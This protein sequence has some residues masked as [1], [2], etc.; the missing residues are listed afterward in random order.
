[1]KI[2][3]KVILPVLFVAA[4][5]IVSV[6]WLDAGYGAEKTV[7]PSEPSELLSKGECEISIYD[8]VFRRVGKASGIDWRL[9]SAMAYHESRFH[10]GA[11]SSRGAVGLMQIMPHVARKYGVSRKDLLNPICNIEL[12]A[13][14]IKGVERSMQLPRTIPADD[15]LALMLACYNGGYAHISD[16][17]NLAEFYGENRYSWE[18][19]SEYLFLL[20]DAD[21]YEHE[22]VSF[23]VFRGSNETIKYVNAVMSRYNYYCRKAELD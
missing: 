18:T 22:A 6:L 19:V 10:K 4:V 7:E 2:F 15:R 8:N 17:C 13:K 11:V 23:G 20:S 12:S 5:A 21:F 1:M 16:A 9:M 3:N 14:I